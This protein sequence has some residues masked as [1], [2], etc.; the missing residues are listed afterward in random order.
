LI[1]E[2]SSLQFDLFCSLYTYI[3]NTVVCI[4][5]RAP[6][7]SLISLSFDVQVIMIFLSSVFLIDRIRLEFLRTNLHHFVN[8]KRANQ[9]C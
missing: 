5:I 9:S 7:K 3:R 2:L 8:R 1:V 6:A 4:N